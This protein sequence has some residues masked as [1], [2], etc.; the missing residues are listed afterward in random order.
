MCNGS[1]NSDG[2]FDFGLMLTERGT[3]FGYDDLIV[4]FEILKG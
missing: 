4:D 2:D 1:R 3:T